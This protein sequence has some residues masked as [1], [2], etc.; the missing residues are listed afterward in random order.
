MKHA[1][2]L[3]TVAVTGALLGIAFACGPHTITI[4]TLE[5]DAGRIP[6]EVVDGGDGR[7]NCPAG[8]FCSRP[9]CG[10]S[11]GTCVGITDCSTS[12]PECGCDGISYQNSCDR[13]TALASF[14]GGGQCAGQQM[15]VP[16]ITCS[17]SSPFS[18]CPNNASCANIFLYRLPP[19]LQA[20]LFPPDAGVNACL[21][22]VESVEQQPFSSIGVCWGVPDGSIPGPRTLQGVC[23]PQCIDYGSAISRGGIYHLCPALDAGP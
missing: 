16:P 12:G 19:Q 5:A 7:G 23:D 22:I 2:A 11:A 6:C 4:A 20:M 10:A 21:S 1:G 8:Q 13:Q 14:A 15:G 3:A 9:L 18:G 17:L